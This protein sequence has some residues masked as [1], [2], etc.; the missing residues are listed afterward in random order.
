[1][2]YEKNL[3]RHAQ[4]LPPLFPGRV[5]FASVDAFKTIGVGKNELG[6]FKSQALMFPFVGFVFLIVPFNVRSV[7]G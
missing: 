3:P 6:Q 5:A 4:G 7:H 2:D 1:M